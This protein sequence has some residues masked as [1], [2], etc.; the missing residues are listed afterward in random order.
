MHPSTPTLPAICQ[1]KLSEVKALACRALGLDPEDYD[2]HD[3]R[4]L[5]QG[6]SVS[7]TSGSPLAAGSV[8]R[9]AAALLAF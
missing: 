9:R 5:Q 1:C 2:V 3:Y 8:A 4:G 6:P 7:A